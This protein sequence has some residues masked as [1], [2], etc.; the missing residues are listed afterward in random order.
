M[1]AGVTGHHGQ[2][3]QSPV[4]LVSSPVSA[5]ATPRLLSWEARTVLERD[6]KPKRVQSLH[7]PV[8][9]FILRPLTSCFLLLYIARIDI[10]HVFFMHSSVNG[11]WGPWSPW[12]T[13]SLTCGGGQQTRK[14]LCNNPA[15]QYGGK[16]CVGEAKDTQMCNKNLCPIGEAF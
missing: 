13:C 5:S 6:G 1:A 9:F 10:Y 7:V 14:R 4:V 11:N 8:S 2:A 16:E 12:D 3:A 15:P